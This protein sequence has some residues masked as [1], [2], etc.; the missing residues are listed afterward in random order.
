MNDFYI[1][2]FNSTHHAIRT[3]K[4]L[5]ESGYKVLTLPTPR[6]I[7]ASCGL[8]IKI[9]KDDICSIVDIMD[10]NSIERRGIFHILKNES[11]NR[12]AIRLQD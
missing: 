2:S 4:I 1:I 7:A 5:Q 8:S 6:E 9:E 10:D 11:G 3:E 12:E